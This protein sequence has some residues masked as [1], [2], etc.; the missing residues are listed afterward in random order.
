MSEKETKKTKPQPKKKPKQIDSIESL[1][2][3]IAKLKCSLQTTE[4]IRDI[5]Q[6]KFDKQQ[7]KFEQTKMEQTI[8]TKKLYSK[9][10]IKRES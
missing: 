10:S 9:K 8:Q 7:T 1:N 6:A 4:S 5:A 3:Q 2:E